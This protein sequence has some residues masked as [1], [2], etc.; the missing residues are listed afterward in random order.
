MSRGILEQQ[1][2]AAQV[3]IAELERERE[4]ADEDEAKLV[5]FAESNARLREAVEKSAC[6]G[7]MTGSSECVCDLRAKALGTRQ[8]VDQKAGVPEDNR[9]R[10]GSLQDAVKQREVQS[11]HPGSTTQ[12]GV[13]IGRDSLD[14]DWTQVDD[15]V[16]CRRCGAVSG[17]PTN[18]DIRM[19]KPKDTV[20][21]RCISYHCQY[22]KLARERCPICSKA[23]QAEQPNE[24]CTCSECE[25]RR[26]LQIAHGN[27][28]KSGAL[29][30]VPTVAPVHLFGV[31]VED[32]LCGHLIEM[33]VLTGKTWKRKL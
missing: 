19:C 22:N 3:R 10:D 27:D 5:R 32:I 24:G 29:P 13:S 12:Q 20:Q 9:E 28:H 23:A 4:E 31:A 14:H 8:G 7:C 6:H 1:L 18:D 16:Q 25:R 15:D 17:S 2:A 33:D 30:P 11:L 21:E 26:S